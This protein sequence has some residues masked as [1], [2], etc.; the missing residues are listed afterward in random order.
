[1]R[2]ISLEYKEIQKEKNKLWECQLAHSAALNKRYIYD[3]EKEYKECAE[4]LQAW[5]EQDQKVQKL[6]QN[7][8]KS[9]GRTLSYD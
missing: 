5:H 8:F 1:M 4:A 2:A 3:T 9:T 7:Y 6:V